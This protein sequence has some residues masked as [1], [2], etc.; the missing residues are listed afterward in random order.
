MIWVL[1]VFGGLLILGMPVAFAIGI[2]GFVYFLQRPELPLTMPVQLVLSETQNFALLAIPTFILAGNLMNESGVANRLLRFA[3]VLTGHMHAG[4]AQASVV[5][6]TLMG[7]VCGSAIA[8]AAMEARILGPAMVKRGYTRGFCAALEGFTGLITIA[9]PPSIGLVLYGS[10]G[11]I[12]IGRLFVGG[13]VPGLLLGLVY[14]T[15]ISVY[16]RRRGFSPERPRPAPPREVGSALLG[17]LWA[18]LFPI[19]LIVTLRFGLFVPSEVGAAA[20]L[21]A[22]LVGL[23]AYR[24]LDWNRLKAAFRS[25]TIDTGMIMLLIA[26]SALISY[27]MKWEMLPQAL[28]ASLLEVSTNRMVTVIIIAVF[29]FALGMVM[30][31]TVMILLL[32][33]ILVP[34]M[35]QLG[36]DLVYFG[37][38]MV[39]TCA[40][41]L[42]TPPVGLTMYSVCSIMQCS[43]QEYLRESWPFALGLALVVVLMIAFPGLVTFLPNLLFG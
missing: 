9:I 8:D 7:G 17:S 23:I 32:T 39:I 13:I 21:Y 11:E 35:R 25:S 18:V 36:V 30:D 15:A 5:L 19:L 4:I 2:S 43:I 20:A 41:G 16:A 38:L 29:L 37:V 34:V 31:S 28:S 1:V 10:I 27:G 24:E 12:S 3:S 33:P 22:L 40:I 26:M 6:S 14:M 42:L